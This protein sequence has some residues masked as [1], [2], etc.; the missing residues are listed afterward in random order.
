MIGTL[1]VLREALGERARCGVVAQSI[2]DEAEL[3]YAY[4]HVLASIGSMDLAPCL[5]P[6]MK[7]GRTRW[8]LYLA[9]GVYLC[10]FLAAALTLR[11]RKTP[12]A[13]LIAESSLVISKGGHKLHAKKANPIH[14]ANLYSHLAPLVLARHYGVPFALWGH[15]LGPFNDPFS[16]WLTCTVL[17]DACRIGVRESLS[18]ELALQMGLSPEKVVQ[19]PDPAF[20]ITPVQTKRVEQLI[21]RHALTPGEFLTVTVRQYGHPQSAVYQ[22]YLNG[23]AMLVQ[24]L[25]QAGFVKQAAVVVH[26][27]GPIPTENDAIPSGLLL[28]RL[29]GLPVCLIQEDLA[30]AELCAL[31]G[32]SKF[33]IGTRF[34]SVILAM[35]G[36][37]PA[38]AISY[39]G[40]KSQGIMRDM[41]L[42]EW[43]TSMEQ[44]EP[45]RLQQRILA[46]D[47]NG[48]RQQI[49]QQVVQMRQA[50]RSATHAL[51]TTVTRQVW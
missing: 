11:Y 41:G 4:R 21:E 27:R 50:F 34:H 15:S 13:R 48:L 17:K 36:G 19:I 16:R 3:P 30:P 37:T 26:T 40:P 18:F 42:S 33:M 49:Q 35:A 39:F 8:G 14:L 43:V 23:V 28:E 2:S 47:L 44:L 46:A 10:R 1:G 6:T 25:L 38:C 5:L 20:M 51:L 29:T 32:Q 24:G 12:G 22:H 7:V 9:A 45:A 31:Y